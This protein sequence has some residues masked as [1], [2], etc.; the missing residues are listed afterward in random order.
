MDVDRDGWMDELSYRDMIAIGAP[1]D[2]VGLHDNDGWVVIAS[3]A[4]TQ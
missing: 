4:A 2:E 3:A 1:E